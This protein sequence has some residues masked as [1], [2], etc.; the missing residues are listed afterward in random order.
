MA[1]HIKLFY[2]LRATVSSALRLTHPGG[3]QPKPRLTEASG[4]ILEMRKRM[5][6]T[7]T[8]DRKKGSLQTQANALIR[9]MLKRA[10]IYNCFSQRELFV[11]ICRSSLTAAETRHNINTTSLL[12]WLFIATCQI[13]LESMFLYEL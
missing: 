13:Y 12:P 2:I 11:A 4:L 5:K 1:S 10:V 9:E 8:V 3:Q 7:S 6:Q